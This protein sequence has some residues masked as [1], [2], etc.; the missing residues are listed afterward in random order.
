MVAAKPRPHHRR[1]R[2]PVD[3]LIVAAFAPELSPL[4]PRVP[5]NG[6]A[7]I[8]D[9]VIATRAI[10]VGLARGSAGLARALVEFAPRTVV[11]IGSCGVYPNCDVAIGEV[12]VARSVSL[13][14][15]ACLEGRG[16][17]PALVRQERLCD[18]P[19]GDSFGVRRVRVANTV[20]ITTDDALASRY[21][22]AGF[23][24]EHLEAFALDAVPE[25][26]ACTAVLAVANRVG[27]DARAEWKSNAERAHRALAEIVTKFCC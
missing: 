16:E 19:L 22:A 27:R 15:A 8:G 23:D 25:E 2:R 21:G 6:E 3:L 12:V 14:D 9:R 5:V 4:S 11:L 7:R 10:G 18:G 24:V 1:M 17:I 26:I 13:A 20:A